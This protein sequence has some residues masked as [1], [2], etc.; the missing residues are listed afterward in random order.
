[1]ALE[2]LRQLIST[3]S[4]SREEDKTATIIY[5]WLAAR[6]V[7]P[8]RK[9]N[10]ILAYSRGF[11]AEARPTL[12]LNSHHDTVRPAAS[13]TR[14]PYSPTVEG[15][16]LYGLGSNDAGGSVVGLM[17][18][19]VDHYYDSDKLPFNILLAITAEEE[20]MGEGGIRSLS[21]ELKMV[22][23]A[24]VGEPTGL[25]SAVGERG[26]V[27]LDCLAKGRS[28]HAAR[29]EGD[30][31][32]YRAIRDI[33]KLQSY[34][35]ERESSLL[36][37]IRLTTTM[38]ECG[39]QHNVVP[40]SCRFVVDCRTTDAYSN[41]EMVDILA[42]EME[43]EITP[44][45]TRIGASALDKSHPLLRAAEALGAV[46]YIS[47]TTSD[48]ALMSWPSLKIGV[49]ESARS[50]SA[51]EWVEVAE[52]ARGVEFYRNYIEKLAQIYETLE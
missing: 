39:T 29:D 44:R 21:E 52:V 30:N 33:T 9:G 13:Y 42:K 43:S 11:D 28:G 15:G 23:M 37:P 17:S 27:V 19:F 16:R 47:P 38:I 31:A 10:N 1:M 25:N 18:A 35:F 40:D 22:D 32:L 36:G 51:D 49:G 41:Q 5:E 14:D 45:S 50:H 12:L 34:R 24:I 7:E 3:P 48:M 6:G 2:L 46:A 8:C 4:H 20:V 26:L